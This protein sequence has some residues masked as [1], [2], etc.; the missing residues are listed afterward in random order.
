MNYINYKG[1]C[2]IETIECIKGLSRIERITLLKEYML[3]DSSGLYYFSQ[4]AV[5]S[6]YN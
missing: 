1:S 3:S 5:K 2:G 4:R 6:F